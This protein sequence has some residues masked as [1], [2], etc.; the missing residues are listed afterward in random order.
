MSSHSLYEKHDELQHQAREKNPW[1]RFHV[2]TNF[3]LSQLCH[4]LIFTIACIPGPSRCMNAS[5]DPA[6]LQMVQ[7]HVNKLIADVD[8]MV[9]EVDCDRETVKNALQDVAADVKEL[10]KR[11][12][13]VETKQIGTDERIET[14]EQRVTQVEEQLQSSVPQISFGMYNIFVFVR[15]AIPSKVRQFF[16]SRMMLNSV[17][18]AFLCG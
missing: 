3:N 10:E 1:L 15:L 8:K 7:Q 11:I 16:G 18:T 9:F 5:L 17:L 2:S 6:L 12:S 4:W 13:A 14:V